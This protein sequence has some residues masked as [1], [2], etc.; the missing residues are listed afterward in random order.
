M[1]QACQAYLAA[2]LDLVPKIGSGP[3]SSNLKKLL[4]KGQVGGAF[5]SWSH[6]NETCPPTEVGGGGFQLSR[7]MTPQVPCLVTR[8]DLEQLCC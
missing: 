5:L 3:T 1:C 4:F 8:F 7:G 6:A 2:V